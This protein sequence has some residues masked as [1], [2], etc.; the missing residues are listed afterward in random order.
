MTII[1]CFLF[2]NNSTPQLHSSW[3]LKDS[4]CDLQ[5]FKDAK[6]AMIKIFHSLRFFDY[7]FLRNKVPF[8]N[9]F[10]NGSFTN[11]PK[12]DWHFL[13]NIQLRFLSNN[14]SMLRNFIE[15]W[16]R[17]IDFQEPGNWDLIF[18]KTSISKH[19]WFYKEILKCLMRHNWNM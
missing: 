16:L 13:R 7:I 10:E 11:A 2:S 17:W 6:N 18:W 1:Q 5:F 3:W 19:F 9:N 14:P 15:V 4:L 12:I 8:Q